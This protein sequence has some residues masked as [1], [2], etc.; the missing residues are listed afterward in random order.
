MGKESGAVYGVRRFGA[1]KNI[2]TF[3]S[4]RR[5]RKQGN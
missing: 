1:S 3:I 2:T 5:K 4:A